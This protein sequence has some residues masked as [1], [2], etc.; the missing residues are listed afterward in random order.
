MELKNIDKLNETG[1]VK[2]FYTTIHDCA[3]KFGK[4]GA[5]DNFSSLAK[6]LKLS[7]DNMVM[8]SQK[9]TDRIKPV[10]NSNGG[11]M[12][13]FSPSDNEYDGMITN[14]KNLL[15]CTL[16]ADCVPVYILD[17]ENRAI[18]MVH[19]GWRG[20]AANISVNAVKMM[21]ERFN[22]RPEDIMIVIGPHICASCYEIG[23]E[24][25]DD[26]SKMYT[27]PE[28]NRFFTYFKGDKYRLDL[29]QAIVISLERIGIRAENI[30]D[31]GLCTKET[32]YLCSWRRDNPVMKS[33]LTGI[34]L[35]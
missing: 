31:V 25:R 6:T 5:M 1:L 17:P 30:Y 19:S 21:S 23:P 29:K 11:E 33:M 9:H 34:M 15:L 28:L 12:I 18:G 22:S 10:D 13:C 20:T 7:T 2:A 26:F 35:I 16:E 4:D 3:W 14:T 32:P 8:V 27:D 24:L